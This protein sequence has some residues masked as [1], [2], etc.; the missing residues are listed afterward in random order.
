MR[1]PENYTRFNEIYKDLWW[2]GQEIAP[3]GEKTKEL[4]SYTYRLPPYYRLADFASRPL[5][6][7]Y[8]RS[9]FRWY[10]IGDLK[11]L[12]ITK[13]AKIWEQ[14]VTDGQLNSNYGHY[15]FRIPG[16]VRY[17]VDVLQQDPQS[18]RAIITILNYTH[19]YIGNRDVPCTSTLN[20]HIRDDRLHCQVHMRSQDAVFGLG[21]DVP[22]FGFVQDLV[23]ALLNREPVR[24]YTLG[25]L[26]VH[27]D[28]LHVYE[29]HFQMVEKLQ[30]EKP[31]GDEHLMIPGK[32]LR[33]HEALRLLECRPDLDFDF[34][35][36]LYASV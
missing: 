1:Y 20:F 8:I 34:S 6:Y 21:N 35:R 31:L 9:E 29:R 14:C 19:L 33:R 13:H 26:T 28:S 11:D 36:W 30:G 2:K 18:R 4:R 17:V 12:S 15:L 23:L 16:G 10:L 7:D 3:R 24:E 25:D 27:V 22:F 32:P 5:N